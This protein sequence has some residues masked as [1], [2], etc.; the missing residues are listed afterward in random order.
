M[1]QTKALA[2]NPKDEDTLYEK[3][4]FLDILGNH[5]GAIK[6][7]DKALAINPHDVDALNKK[8]AALNSLGFV[9]I[10]DNG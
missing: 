3:G 7:F 4:V 9:I 8:G 5:S 1:H 10:A 2:I 6:Y